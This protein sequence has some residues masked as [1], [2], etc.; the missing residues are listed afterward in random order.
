MCTRYTKKIKICFCLSSRDQ[1]HSTSSNFI[2]KSKSKRDHCISCYGMIFF[3]R[4]LVAL[5]VNVVGPSF[6]FTSAP[7]SSLSNNANHR[8]NARC[9]K[10]DH[11]HYLTRRRRRHRLLLMTLVWWVCSVASVGCFVVEV[12]TPLRS[13]VAANRRR[14][15]WISERT[16]AINVQVR[17]KRR[18]RREPTVGSS[19]RSSTR[20]QMKFTQVISDVDDTIKSS[21][22]VAV[23]GVAYMIYSHVYSK[24]SESHK[25]GEY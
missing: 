4:Q 19:R 3:F 21:G 20:C 14:Q 18:H 13:S 15:Q 24:F 5:F 2:S 10:Q 11:C 22:G 12:S 16:A 6:S 17:N 1:N 7:E 23:A 8:S 9:C 25:L